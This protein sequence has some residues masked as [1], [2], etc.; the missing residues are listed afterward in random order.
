M[1]G[2]G[3]LSVECKEECRVATTASGIPNTKIF[4][5]TS[6]MDTFQECLT[7]ILQPNS[8]VAKD[9]GRLRD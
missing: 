4:Q 7:E 2:L 9:N 1:S 3:A 8:G 6:K 5:L